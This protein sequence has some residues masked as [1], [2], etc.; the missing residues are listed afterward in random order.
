MNVLITGGAQGI[1]KGITEH[2]LSRRHNVVIA[3]IDDEAG[4]A[5]LAEYQAFAAQLS[6]IHCDTGSEAAVRACV[7]DTLRRHSKLHA[8]VNNAAIADP[9][10][11]P[12]EN[13]TLKEWDRRLRINLTGYFLMTKYAVPA[14]REVKGSIVN[15]ASTRAHQSE[16]DTEAYA[17]SKGG[18]VALTHAL[19]VSLGPQVRVNGISPG[20]I[21]TEAWQAPSRRESPDLS[22]IDHEQHLAGRVGVP[23][24]IAT[25][26]E[27]LIGDAAEF[28]TGQEFILDGGMTRK[29]IYAP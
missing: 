24:D 28:I 6:F 14:L 11:G 29:M 12:I 25:M 5:C 13:L 9:H 27:Y 19:A 26:V 15:I 3:D 2:L 22:A 16:P 21:S 20:W 17:A 18:V 4:E 10:T 23:Q 7:K 8:V 1:G